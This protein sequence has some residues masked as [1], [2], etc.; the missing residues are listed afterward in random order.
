MTKL[1]IKRMEKVLTC[2]L[3]LCGENSHLNPHEKPQVTTS[4]TNKIAININSIFSR[5]FIP[6]SGI[7][8]T[9]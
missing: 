7:D 2:S 8:E 3:I 1:K 6:V 9:L 4:R 5:A